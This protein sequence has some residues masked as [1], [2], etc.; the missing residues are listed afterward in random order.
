MA[1]YDTI[2]QIAC[3]I[4][5]ENCIRKRVSV[6]GVGIYREK[7]LL[8]HLKKSGIKS[9]YLINKNNMR[10]VITM[11]MT[12]LI[13]KALKYK[14]KQF[15]AKMKIK[16]AYVFFFTTP[17]LRAHKSCTESGRTFIRW[18]MANFIW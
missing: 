15:I 8:K 5:I 18:K 12:I 17:P 4:C 11:V 7:E 1:K 2:R 6:H 16:F 9:Q 10:K 14:H 13:L 3:S